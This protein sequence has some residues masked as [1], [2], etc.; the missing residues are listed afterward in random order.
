MAKLPAAIFSAS[1]ALLLILSSLNAADSKPLSPRERRAASQ[2]H[3]VEKRAT[4]EDIVGDLTAGAA[5]ILNEDSK[6]GFYVLY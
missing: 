4:V 5:G 2:E 3:F 6:Y 1:L